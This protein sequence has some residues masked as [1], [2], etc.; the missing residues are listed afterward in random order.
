MQALDQRCPSWQSCPLYHGLPTALFLLQVWLCDTNEAAAA[1]LLRT[2]VSFQKV[3]LS[4]N[5]V[6]VVHCVDCVQGTQAYTHND[7][8]LQTVKPNAGAALLRVWHW[9][10]ARPVPMYILSVHLQHRCPVCRPAR[11]SRES[12][13]HRRG[14]LD[15]FAR[16]C[17]VGQMQLSPPVVPETALSSVHILAWCAMSWQQNVSQQTHS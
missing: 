13:H 14:G 2:K 7:W 15:C 9:R 10:S 6:C 4:S 12:G 8:T 1:P 5:P 3:T 11:S 17:S 16:V